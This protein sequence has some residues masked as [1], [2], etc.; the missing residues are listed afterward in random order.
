MTSGVLLSWSSIY[1]RLGSLRCRMGAGRPAYARWCARGR[2]WMKASQVTCSV[3]HR[4][5]SGLVGSAG[6]SHGGRSMRGSKVRR[7]RPGT[8]V[9]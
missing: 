6:A 1:W 3:D 4:A 5:I 9:Q 2:V 8:S 7:V